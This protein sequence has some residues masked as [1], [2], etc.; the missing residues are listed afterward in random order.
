MWTERQTDMMN[1]ILAFGHF[2]KEPTKERAL[3]RQADFPISFSLICSKSVHF[4]VWHSTSRRKTA[5]YIL[6]SSG[7]R[8]GRLN[9]PPSSNNQFPGEGNCIDPRN[10]S[11]IKF[12]AFS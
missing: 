2:A 5:A 10:L 11:H 3:E 6:L 12:T 1:V 9:R 4:F 7:K 8:T